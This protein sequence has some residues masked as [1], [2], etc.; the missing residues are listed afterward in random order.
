MYKLL[1][2]SLPFSFFLTPQAFAQSPNDPTTSSASILPAITVRAKSNTTPES[3]TRSSALTKF[4][5][6][7]L[8][9][10][11]T[12]SHVSQAQLKTHDIQRISD[13][14]ALVSGVFYQ[15][16]YGGGFWDN[17]SFRGFSTDPN[18]GTNGLRNGL[19][20]LNGIHAPRD[21][22]NIES[23]D[24]LKGPMASLYGQGA[25]GGTLNINTKQPKWQTQNEL[26]L[27][28][29]TQQEYRVSLDR[30]A[31]L[32][33]QLAYR[34]GLAYENNQSFR[35]HV[36]SQHYFIAPQ[37]AWKISDRTQLNLDTEFSQYQGTFDRGIAAFNNQIL[38]DKKTFLGEPADGDMRVKDNLYQLRLKHQWNDQWHSMTS[39]S[40][41]EGQRVGTSTEAT[42]F[43]ADGQTINRFRRY[44]NFH[45]Q[46]TQLQQQLTGKFSTATIKHE[47]VANLETGHYVIDQEQAR[48]RPTATAPNQINV[49]DPI[50]GIYLPAMPRT[51][52]STETQERTSINL[53][54]QI[55]L[56]SQWNILL[57]ARLES[58]SQD[59]NNKLSHHDGKRTFSPISPRVGI[60]YRPIDALSFY[61]N[62]GRAFELNTGFDRLGQTFN[63]EKTEGLELG[64][65]YRFSPKTWANIAVFQLHKRNVLT[66]DPV[67]ASYQ[68]TAGKV[69]S[70][71]LELDVQQQLSDQLTLTANYTLTRASVVADETLPK[72][73]RLK[74]IP[75]HSAN[76]SADYAFNLL[77]HSAG[78]TGN[79]N[80]YSSR[81]GNYADNGFTLPAFTVVNAGGYLQLNPETRIQ[82]SINNLFNKTYYV[83]SYSTSWIQPGSPIK[84]SLSLNW[85][86]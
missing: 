12:K 49:Y 36:N 83:S 30:T 65:K 68:I 63:P 79:I 75:N 2:S 51:I 28:G 41:E 18:M 16:S 31:A 73:A 19:T 35:E 43:N 53:Q 61:A 45:T 27:R 52:L 25:I 26:D 13:T 62:Y 1:L 29:T 24:F 54:D 81:S 77:N 74:N 80:Y 60:N 67:D 5:H 44:R 86:F 85:K 38:M 32:N 4:S 69:Q 6:D 50:Y 84:A 58:L 57:G 39:L 78:L 22:V 17:Y 20:Q 33:E 3:A 55:F 40:H 66:T 59:I 72:G 46:D 70:H 64:S 14:L 71:G 23:I 37:L 42:S 15:D 47:L 76:L 21:M 7:L 56:N 10:P 48:K 82:L 34:L 9:V 11:L 8:D